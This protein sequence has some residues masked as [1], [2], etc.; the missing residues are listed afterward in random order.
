M[1][2]S[3]TSKLPIPKDASEFELI[4]ADVL[5]DMSMSDND[6][7]FNHVKEVYSSRCGT[8]AK[9]CLRF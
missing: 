5:K 1:P 2:T 4:T 3:T 9:I 8:D 6:I 7:Y